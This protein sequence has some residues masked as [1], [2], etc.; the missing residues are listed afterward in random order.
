MELC[1]VESRLA[2]N[3]VA[4]QIGAIDRDLKASYERQAANRNGQIV[5]SFYTRMVF[6]ESY[7]IFDRSIMIRHKRPPTK[8]NR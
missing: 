6:F 3:E 2:R 8:V 5:A 1:A 4:D 7:P